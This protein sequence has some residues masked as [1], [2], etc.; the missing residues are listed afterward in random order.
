METSDW[1]SLASICI[2]IVSIIISGGIAIWIVKY[3]QS[4]LDTEQKLR[5][6]FCEEVKIIRDEYRKILDEI[7]ND[8]LRP[9]KFQSE[10]SSLNN[11][12][13]DIMNHLEQKFGVNSEALTN[14]QL[15][16]NT[17]VSEDDKFIHAYN[18]NSKVKFSDEF[19]TQIRNIEANN[20]SVF[21]DLIEQVY[22]KRK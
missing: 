2:D 18:T 6:Y 21:N 13:T 3:I 14:F 19:I 20:S 9:K 4:K 8:Q 5:D 17:K 10:M 22:E 15:A 12:S 11:K 1:L 16:L 7:Y